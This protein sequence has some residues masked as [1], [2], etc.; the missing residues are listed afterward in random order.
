MA[1]RELRPTPG[2]TN[3]FPLALRAC[4]AGQ[5]ARAELDA[6]LASE[7]EVRERGCRVLGRPGNPLANL[8]EALEDVY[9][10]VLVLRDDG[11]NALHQ[12]DEAA[13]E[14]AAATLRREMVL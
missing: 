4:H 14:D 3:P 12:I 13:L 10:A 6:Y 5:A 8:A 11:W 1:T 2:V 7:A 9:A